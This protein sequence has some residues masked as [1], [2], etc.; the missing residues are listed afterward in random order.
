MPIRIIGK[1]KDFFREV[2]PNKKPVP[3]QK[4]QVVQVNR[5]ESRSQTAKASQKYDSQY[6]KSSSAHASQNSYRQT[7][8]DSTVSMEDFF[9]DIYSNSKYAKANVQER[10]QFDDESSG[11]QKLQFSENSGDC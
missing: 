8:T 4:S 11:N 3:V 6:K 5:N 10:L 7:Q 9:K 1:E 2:Q